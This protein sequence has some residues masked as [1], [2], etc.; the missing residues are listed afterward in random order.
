MNEN[1][2]ST[3]NPYATPQADLSVQRAPHEAELAGRWRR[4]GAAVIDTIIMIAVALGPIV[5]FLG[6]WSS[7]L[8]VAESGTFLMKLGISACSFVIYLLING[9]F[10]AKDGQSIGKKLLGIKIVRT[11]GSQ[12]DFVRIVTR[13]LLPVQVAGLIPTVG[14]FLGLIDALFIFRQSK[15]CLHDDIADTVVIRI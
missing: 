14:P 7:Y 8:S 4:L 12:A 10:L 2:S 6:G 15:K 3:S 5:F 9:Y 1:P 11:N 13:R